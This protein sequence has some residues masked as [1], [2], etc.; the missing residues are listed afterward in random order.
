[1]KKLHVV[2]DSMENTLHLDVVDQLEHEF[3]FEFEKTKNLFFRFSR[4]NST[5]KTVVGFLRNQRV[6]KKN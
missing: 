2:G 1:M 6:R 4:C 3:E 5:C